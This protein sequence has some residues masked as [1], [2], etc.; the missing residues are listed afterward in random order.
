MFQE[1]KC[2]NTTNFYTTHIDPLILFTRLTAILQCEIGSVVNFD[3][4]ITA[5]PASLFKEG[6]TRKPQKAVLRNLLLDKVIPCR[7]IIPNWCVVD[8]GAL[9]H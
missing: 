5:E 4:E 6:I 7:D 9:L 2:F 8:G 1:I 3:Y